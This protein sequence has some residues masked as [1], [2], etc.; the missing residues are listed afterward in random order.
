VDSE[1]RLRLVAEA[2]NL[3]IDAP[4]IPLPSD[5]NDAWKIDELVLRICW[6]GDRTRLQRE[7]LILEHLP[8]EVPHGRLADAG[9][10]DDLTWTLTHW[11]PGTSLSHWWADLDRTQ[12]RTAA[13]QFGHALRALHAWEPSPAVRVALAARPVQ[14]DYD[15]VIGADLNP[16]PVDRAL[17]LVE[18]ATHLD[19][20]DQQLVAQLDEE[21]KRL[22]PID[23]LR[24]SSDG[25]VVHG[26][27]Q[28]NNVIWDG[29]RLVA[30]LDYEWARLGPPDLELQPLLQYDDATALIRSV[31]AAYPGIAAHPRF[32][33]RLWLYDL[34]ATLRDLL[35]KAPL[36]ATDD[37]P[38][39][40]PKRRLAIVVAGPGYIEAV[41]SDT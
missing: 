39:W 22:R 36:P 7:A 5:S 25:V 14:P 8:D 33:E 24:N 13:E 16:L 21:M 12:R 28:L 4:P 20:V 23:P 11:V 32:V 27:A 38:P 31:V 6:R 34:S 37:L 15:D 10:I 2:A 26:D 29:M 1:A 3:T 19:N 35:V 41:L 9:V 40:H 17:R 18:P 30:L